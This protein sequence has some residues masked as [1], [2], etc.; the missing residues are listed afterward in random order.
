MPWRGSWLKRSFQALIIVGFSLISLGH[1]LAAQ[2]IGISVTP[3]SKRYDLRPGQTVQGNF[4]IRNGGDIAVD[5][6]L[7]VTPLNIKNEQY[8]KDYSK[9]TAIDASS[10]IKLNHSTGKLERGGKRVV[11]FTLTVPQDAAPGGHYAV[12]FA[13]TIIPKGVQADSSVKSTQRVGEL[14]YIAVSGDLKTSGSV[15]GW[16]S[17]FWQNEPPLL[18]TLRMKNDGNTHYDANYSVQVTDVFGNVK[19]QMKGENIILPD[20]TRRID[21][22]W[23]SAPDFGLYKV[24]GSVNFAGKDPALPSQYVLMLTSK[25]FMTMFAGLLTILLAAYVLRHSKKS[26]PR[27]RRR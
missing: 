5:Y 15:A 16:D 8:E 7:S 19:T 22:T 3:A 25:F 14:F 6:K 23:N 13:E 21:I 27:N 17:A 2:K 24:G 11:S 12:A 18:A 20:T 1:L 9:V 4:T 26:G 10:W